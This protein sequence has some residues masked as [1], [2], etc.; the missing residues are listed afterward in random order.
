MVK[1]DEYFLYSYYLVCGATREL[2]RRL[3]RERMEGRLKMIQKGMI[4]PTSSSALYTGT[5]SILIINA[6]IA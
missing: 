1:M 5:L 4:Y 3:C 2:R 6:T